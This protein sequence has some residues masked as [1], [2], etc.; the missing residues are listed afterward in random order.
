MSEDETDKARTPL[1]VK[2]FA[3]VGVVLIVLVLVILIAGRG[4]HGPGRHT[5]AG[6]GPRGHTGPPAGVTHD[7][8]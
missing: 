5:G 2:V 4:G 3:I 6:D 1:W 7:Q 8:P